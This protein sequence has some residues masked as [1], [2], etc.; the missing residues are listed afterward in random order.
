[1]YVNTGK[2]WVQVLNVVDTNKVPLV[3]LVQEE[4]CGIVHT[5]ENIYDACVIDFGLNF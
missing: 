4:W 2:S 3:I 5:A 1:M